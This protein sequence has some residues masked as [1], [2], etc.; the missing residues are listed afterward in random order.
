M[1]VGDRVKIVHSPY[2]AESLQ[3]G[4]T[5]RIVGLDFGL[6][7]I[8]TDDGHADGAGDLDWPFDPQELEVVNESR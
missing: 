4:R 6:V 8:V 5:G 7:N 3:A 1:K 2:M